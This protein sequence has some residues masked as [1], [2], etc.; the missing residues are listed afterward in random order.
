MQGILE[1]S[2][3]S[4]KAKLMDQMAEMSKPNPQQEQLAN[5]AAQL[6]VAGKQADVQVKQS[7]AILKKAQAQKASV[8]ANLEPR[9]VNAKVIAALS[10]NLDDNA[11]GADFEKRAKIADLMLKEKDINSNERIAKM[12]MDVQRQNKIDQTHLQEVSQTLQ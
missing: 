8:E 11:E 5:Q 9:V 7:D 3:L 6:D 2:S 1:N 12:Q 10:N 4:N